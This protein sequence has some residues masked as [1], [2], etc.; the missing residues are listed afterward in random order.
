ML[1]FRPF[2][3][4]KGRKNRI[5]NHFC[6]Y[7]LKA[8][9]FKNSIIKAIKNSTG[10][11]PPTLKIF[12]NLTEQESFDIEEQIIKHFG[13]LDIQTGILSNHTD[14]RDGQS[15]CNRPHLAN[16]KEVYQYSLEGSFI[17]KWD[18]LMEVKE[19]LDINVSNIPT[20]IKRNGTCCNFRWSYTYLGEKLNNKIKSQMPIKH[21]EV[22][23]IDPISGKILNVFFSIRDAIEKSNIPKITASGVDACLRGITQT[24]CGFK[25]ETNKLSSGLNINTSI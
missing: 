16:R 23:Q 14:G 11:N 7:S 4:G 6:N 3:V 21:T 10:K 22:K 9:T 8:K 1:N 5:A 24:H 13:R 20:C 19:E 18:S 15:G 12:E 2:Y 25:W 17:R